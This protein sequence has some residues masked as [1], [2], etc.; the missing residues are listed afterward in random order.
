MPGTIQIDGTTQECLW[1]T[2]TDLMGHMSNPE[3]VTPY[4]VTVLAKCYNFDSVFYTHRHT[5][6]HKLS[7]RQI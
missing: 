7:L 3:L 2:Q 5:A 4:H 6:L 1:A